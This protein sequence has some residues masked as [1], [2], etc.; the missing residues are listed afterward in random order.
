MAIWLRPL[1]SCIAQQKRR[2]R[3]AGGVAF[4]ILAFEILAFEILAFESLAFEI[5]APLRRFKK[6]GARF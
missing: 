5:V 4:E 2:L 3:R 1:Q 6:A